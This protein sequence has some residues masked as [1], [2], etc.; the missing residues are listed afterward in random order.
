MS[1]IA[2]YAQHQNAQRLRRYRDALAASCADELDLTR[3]RPAGARVIASMVSR[4]RR[5]AASAAPKRNPHAESVGA[6]PP[7][8]STASAPQP[9]AARGT[10]NAAPDPHAYDVMDAADLPSWHPDSLHYAGQ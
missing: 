4:D 6:M 3:R 7:P 5:K 9:R 8:S 10:D 2:T 1:A